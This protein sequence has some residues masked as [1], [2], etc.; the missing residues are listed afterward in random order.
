MTALSFTGERGKGVNISWSKVGV[1]LAALPKSSIQ[2]ATSF[3]EFLTDHLH[4]SL[5]HIMIK[6]S[7][8]LAPAPSAIAIYGALEYRFGNTAAWVMTFVFEALGFAA[9]YAKTRLEEHNRTTGDELSTDK[10]DWAIRAYFAVTELSILLF[11]VVPAWAHYFATA[12]ANRDIVEALIHTAPVVFPI[13]SYIGANIYALMDVLTGI[14]ERAK[15]LAD[16]ETAK[17]QAQLAAVMAEIKEQR[18]RYADDMATLKQ[19]HKNEVATLLATAKDRQDDAVARTAKDVAAE[20][21]PQ[22]AE[23]RAELRLLRKIQENAITPASATRQNSNEDLAR[24]LGE[25]SSTEKKKI[26]E[27][28]NIVANHRIE[29]QEQFIEVSGWAARTAQRYWATAIKAGAIYKNGDNA[30]HIAGV[31]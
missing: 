30:Y 23:M 15:K 26:G 18:Q 25:L 24:P 10:A 19:A 16:D 8:L 31:Q 2:W 1:S 5:A 29:S 3:L 28:A 11:E 7:P 20:Y 4:V 12:P 22:L 17:L 6:A 27:I 13:F 21:E 9:V 14:G